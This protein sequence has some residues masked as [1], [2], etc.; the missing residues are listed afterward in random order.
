MEIK[1]IDYL[2][3]WIV[4]NNSM[5]RWWQHKI[6]NLIDSYSYGNWRWAESL[7]DYTFSYTAEVN[8]R[9]R[10]D[11]YLSSNFRFNFDRI[12]IRFWYDVWIMFVQDVNNRTNLIWLS[13]PSF[14]I[15]FKKMKGILK[16]NLSSIGTTGFS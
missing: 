6:D 12:M 8:I 4:D 1:S 7:L 9:S 16:F 5:I 13:W 3:V 2:N 14:K 15:L 10:Y 11:Y